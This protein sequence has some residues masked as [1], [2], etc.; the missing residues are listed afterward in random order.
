MTAGRNALSESY[1]IFLNV[2]GAVFS[3]A[4]TSVQLIQR[5]IKM[6]PFI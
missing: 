1:Q 2:G 4:Y 6:M 3:F 5:E